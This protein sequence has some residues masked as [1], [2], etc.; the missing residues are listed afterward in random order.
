[1]KRRE[2]Y[3]TTGPR[4][5]V[6]F[7][8]GF[9]FTA[10]DANSRSPAI[11][12]YTKGVPMG[13]DLDRCTGGQGADLPGRGAEG[14]DRRKPRS[15]PD[16]QGLARRSRRGAREAS[17]TSRGRATASSA[18]TA[19]CRRSATRSTSPNATWTNTIGAP[20]LIAVW[21]DPDF[22]PAQR[23]FYYGR[24]H[25]NPD[26]ALDG[27]RRQVF[28]PDHAAGSADDHHRARLHVAD[29]VHAGS[30]Q[31]GRRRVWSGAAE[32]AGVAV[33]AGLTLGTMLIFAIRPGRRHP[34]A[35]S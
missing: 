13:G 22:D 20:E 5:V 24:G 10:D 29:L 7:F 18:R 2:T 27:L 33:G 30:T 31:T 1:M 12:G 14:S 21:S 11:A 26:A 35:I 16:R 6:R 19:R 3:A 28:R 34:A 9:D 8:G 25:R 17:T 4:M 15:L 23:A 32:S